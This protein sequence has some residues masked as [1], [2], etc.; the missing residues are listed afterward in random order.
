[1]IEI[2]TEGDGPPRNDSWGNWRF[3]ESNFTLVHADDYEVDLEDMKDSSRILD[4]IA[5][6]SNKSSARTRYRFGAA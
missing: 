1:M 6:V 4:W 5:Q 2:E 3:V